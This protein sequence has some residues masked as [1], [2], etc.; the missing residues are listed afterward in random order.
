MPTGCIS[1]RRVVVSPHKCPD[2]EI[3]NREVSFSDLFV[4]LF[5]IVNFPHFFYIQEEIRFLICP[6]ML[7]SCL[8]CEWM[9]DHEAIIIVGAQRYSSYT[10]YEPVDKF[11][12]IKCEVVAVDALCFGWGRLTYSSQYDQVIINRELN[13]AFAGFYST[14]KMCRPIATGHWGCGAFGGDKQ[15]KSEI[16]IP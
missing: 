7:I 12:R 5:S 1:F 3:D 13:K 8:L 16:R 10:G 9:D 14:Q 2:W 15:L 6:E 11:G 4:N